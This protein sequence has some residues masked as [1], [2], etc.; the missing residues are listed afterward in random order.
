MTERNLAIR[1]TVL[2]G[3]KVKA[4]LRE[5]G[6]TGEKSLKRIELAGNPASLGLKA[7][8]AAANDVR[9]AAVGMATQ[10]GPVGAGLVALG[11]AGIAAATV[12]AGLTYVLK[13]SISAG[14]EAERAFNRISAV[15]KATGSAS[16]L[17]A[18][19]LEEFAEGIERA[20]LATSEQ[21]LDAASVLTT[22][23]SVSGDTFKRALGLAEDLSV[24]FG[25]D[26]TSAS[27]QLGKAL[28]EPSEGLS[29]LRRVGVVFTDSQKDLIKSLSDTGQ[30]VAAQNVILD[31]LQAKIGGA[32]AGEKKGLVGAAN[33]LGDAWDNMLKDLGRTEDV[34]G[35]VTI[36]FKG[37]TNIFDYIRESAQPSI[38]AQVEDVT[39]QLQAAQAAVEKLKAPDAGGTVFSNKPL[40]DLQEKR[41]AELQTRLNKVISDGQQEFDATAK[42]EAEARKGQDEAAA[43]GRL[44]KLTEQ[45]KQINDALDKLVSDPA[46]KIAKINQEL[47]GT[48]LRL[49]TLREKDG[50]TDGK[51]D[52]AI[53][54]AEKLARSQIDAVQK[55]INE[56]AATA[57]ASNRKVIDDLTRGITG[58]ADKRQAFIEQA[59]SRLNKD[60]SSSDKADAK[61]LAGQLFDQQAYQEAEKVIDDLQDK[62]KG[63]TD[64]RTTFIK[65]TLDRVSTSASPEIRKRVE[66]LAGALYDQGIA[67]EKL[68]KLKEDGQK[69]TESTRDAT[70][71]YAAEVKRLKELL[72]A[73]AISQDTYNLAMANAGKE[74]LKGRK[75][76]EAGAQR[77]FA[78]YQEQAQDSASAVE[79]AFTKGMKATE[80][81]ITDAVTSGGASLSSLGDLA[82]SIVADITRMLVQKSIT[83]PLFNAI[84]GSMGEGGA[85]EG[86]LGSIFHEGGIAGGAAPSR[87][88]HPAVFAGA[89]RYHSG[90]IAGLKPNEVPAILERGERII[91]NGRKG[92]GRMGSSVN[93]TMNI[94]TPDANSFRSSKAQVTAE[95]AK[96]LDR[97]R[98]NL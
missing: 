54:D 56:A 90:G 37:L 28:E 39:K 4:E 2:D 35:P 82:N 91:P 80:D 36:F 25:T 58:I 96:A 30:T 70:A 72:D 84:S 20:T 87:I 23:R 60:A 45:K 74:Q 9:G 40:I 1:L 67:E 24:V 10:L 83:G 48:K 18:K 95:A 73:G 57:A 7:V 69:V 38:G 6:E 55:P 98:R 89:P 22:F 34:A 11:P 8:S 29:A 44:D 17:T 21:V 76:A 42:A 65:D 41:V 13:E 12:V 52:A 27:K 26:L 81:A 3:G 53:A 51:V 50:K 46:T 86:I 77:A 94:T 97:A 63:V 19:G 68:K 88:V 14:G 15:L 31:A 61:R 62:L 49:N 66:D 64:K 32:A 33:D 5:V 47:D 85:L 59:V 78:A 71:T 92:G 75:D 43:Q 93:V 16:G 79:A